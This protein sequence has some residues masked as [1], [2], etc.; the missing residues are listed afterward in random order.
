MIN[1]TDDSTIQQTPKTHKTKI[2]QCS[3]KEKSK[4]KHY[5]FLF[6]IVAIGICRIMIQ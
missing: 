3:K 1:K 2:V 6:Y 4:V 5:F